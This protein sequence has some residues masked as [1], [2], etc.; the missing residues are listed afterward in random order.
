M[1]GYGGGVVHD[2]NSQCKGPGVSVSEGE[3]R[4]ER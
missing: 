4:A 1:P 2:G 3:M